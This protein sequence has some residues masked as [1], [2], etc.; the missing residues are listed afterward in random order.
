MDL[1]YLRTGSQCCVLPLRLPAAR[2]WPLQVYL[3]S[4]STVRSNERFR[5]HLRSRLSRVYIQ[6]LNLI[7]RPFRGPSGP[8]AAAKRS[9]RTRKIGTACRCTKR[10][11]IFH[12]GRFVSTLATI[13][14]HH[15]RLLAL[16]PPSS[17][18]KGQVLSL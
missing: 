7:A 5:G 1:S 12:L 17:T 13:L 18:I 10:H 8:V 14:Q 3:S 16:F 6:I 11:K 9:E 15:V 4:C 2:V